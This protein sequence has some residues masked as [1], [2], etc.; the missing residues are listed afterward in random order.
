MSKHVVITGA[1][2]FVG[3][4]LAEYLV[5]NGLGVT[6][7]TR[8]P[9]NCKKYSNIINWVEA[10][11]TIKKA[12]PAKFDILIHCA[13]VLPSVCNDSDR[14]Y[15]DNL[16]MSTSVF[17]Q[18]IDAEAKLI[19][20]LSSMSVYGDI[21]VLKIDEDTKFNNQ[22]IYGKAKYEVEKRLKECVS[23]GLK[24]GISIRL[25]GTVGRGSH[26]NFISDALRCILENK[27]IVI[28]NPDSLFNNIVFVEDLARFILRWASIA[29][30]GYSM[31]NLAATNPISIRDVIKALYSC[32][33]K[34]EMVTY[35]NELPMPF[36]ISL[37]K[38]ISL[39]YE[40]R[41]VIESI[42]E[43]VRD[44]LYVSNKQEIKIK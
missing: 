10:D 37:D 13:A 16:V 4:Y 21:R 5:K 20:Y 31:I 11:L 9:N 2:G 24:S 33:N 35:K 15:A 12:L 29:H 40:P 26:H 18:A 25:P 1:G 36:L 8:S 38:A 28:K 44:E 34:S 17:K 32:S 14:L 41:T 42:T 30:S 39:G 3:N 19:I 7:I 23:L 6:A 43:F 27:K 22:T